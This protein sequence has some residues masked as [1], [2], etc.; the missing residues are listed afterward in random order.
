MLTKSIAD[1]SKD[2]A[3][4]QTIESTS[5]DILDSTVPIKTFLPT[6][7]TVSQSSS[8]TTTSTTDIITTLVIRKS[9]TNEITEI[10]SEISQAQPRIAVKEFSLSVIIALLVCVLAIIFVIFVIHKCSKKKNSYQTSKLEMGNVH[11]NDAF[12][13]DVIIQKI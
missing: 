10:L 12:D 6:K 4:T 11:K 7:P 13:D 5:S 1:E 9:T 3:K 2:D 8:T